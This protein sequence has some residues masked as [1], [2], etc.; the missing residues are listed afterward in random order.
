MNLAPYLLAGLSAFVITLLATPA[1]RAI[2]LASGLIDHPDDRKVHAR[3]T[4][5]L[6]GAAI[7]IGVLGAGGI[8]YFMRDFREVFTLS[9]EALGIAAGALVV[10]ALGTVDDLRSLPAPV[11]LAGQVFASGILFLAGVKM[12][13]IL[14]PSEIIVL[15]DDVSVLVTVLWLVTMM[16]AVNLIDGLDGL[17][18]GVVAIAAASFFVYTFDVAGQNLLGEAPAAPLAAIIIVGA[19]LGFLRYNFHPA[20]IF[21]GDSGSM[22]LGLLLGPPP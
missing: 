10:F 17:A 2:A 11:K 8:A 1:V 3:P 6:G 5:T 12:Q 20:S 16:N 21:M 4:P 19:A 7:F 15:G 14:L 9:S 18:A 22:P 13:F